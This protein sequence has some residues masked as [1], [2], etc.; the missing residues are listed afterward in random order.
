MTNDLLIQTE[1][2]HRNTN[3]EETNK[4]KPKSQGA[5]TYL[6]P[7]HVS[8][9]QTRILPAVL[10]SKHWYEYQNKIGLAPKNPT[11]KNKKPT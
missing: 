10:P 7:G 2:D 11:S 4:D 8:R 1:T 3:K 6:P 9:R 5:E